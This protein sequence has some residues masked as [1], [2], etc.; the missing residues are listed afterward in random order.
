MNSEEY[1]KKAMRTETAAKPHLSLLQFRFLHAAM[2]LS[3]EA[4][5]ILDA[6][7]KNIY[8][9]RPLDIINIIEELGDIFWYCAQ[10]IDTLNSNGCNVTFEYLMDTNIAKLKKRYPYRFTEQDANSRDLKAERKALEE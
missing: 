10:M 6:M 9:D 5:E 4:N 8:Y 7:K 3:T 2:G 1:I